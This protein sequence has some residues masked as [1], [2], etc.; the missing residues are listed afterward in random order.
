M[1]LKIMRKAQVLS[2]RQLWRVL[3]NAMKGNEMP[4]ENIVLNYLFGTHL[5]GNV[6][7]LLKSGQTW[8]VYVVPD[9]QYLILS[10]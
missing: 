9:T 3:E 8:T 2:F 1:C 10:S 6:E 7:E 5:H 4:S